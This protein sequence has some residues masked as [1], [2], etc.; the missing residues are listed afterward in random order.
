MG[1]TLTQGGVMSGLPTSTGAFIPQIRV[2]DTRSYLALV[3]ELWP[4]SGVFGQVHVIG[5]VSPPES[6]FLE[7]PF[8]S[9]DRFGPEPITSQ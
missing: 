1:M 3:R 7:A 2:M 5:A 8:H 6:T 4:I 9:H